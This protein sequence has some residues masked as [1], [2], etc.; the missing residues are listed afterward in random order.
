[1]SRD[2][3]IGSLFANFHCFMKIQCSLFL[4]LKNYKTRSYIPGTTVFFFD[5]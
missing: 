2:G 5:N 4:G 3:I 1:M